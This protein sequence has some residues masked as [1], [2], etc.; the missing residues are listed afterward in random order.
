MLRS[1]VVAPGNL[2]G[3][4]VQAEAAVRRSAASIDGAAEVEVAAIVETGHAVETS[5]EVTGENVEGVEAVVMTEIGEGTGAILDL[6]PGRTLHADGEETGRGIGATDETGTAIAIGCGEG[7]VGQ[8]LGPNLDPDRTLPHAT[9][10][11]NLRPQ[12][13]KYGM[14]SSGWIRP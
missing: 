9:G 3:L 11:R 1:R 13:G 2:E 8:G 10:K 4:G 5:T 14:G 6:G 12:K 7:V